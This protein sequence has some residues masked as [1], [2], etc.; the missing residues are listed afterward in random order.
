METMSGMRAAGT[1]SFWSNDGSST[2]GDEPTDAV[3]LLV[4]SGRYSVA[5]GDTSLAT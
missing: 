3:P 5:L 2:T 4:S 1:T